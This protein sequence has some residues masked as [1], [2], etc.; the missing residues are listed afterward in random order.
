MTN[1]DMIATAVKN[2]RGKILDTCEIKNIVIG[3]FPEFTE[4]SL[5]P[6]DHAFG[7]KSCCSCVGT[8][9]QIFDRIEP[10]KYLVRL[11]E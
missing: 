8:S 2:Y 3:A 5:L 7:N 11:K 4:G 10:N 6:N 9:R 1:H